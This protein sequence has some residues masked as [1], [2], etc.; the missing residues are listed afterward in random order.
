MHGPNIDAWVNAQETALEAKTTRAANP[1]VET[2]EVLWNEFETV[3]KAAWKDTTRTQSAYE[4]LMK[5]EMKNGDIDTYIATFERLTDAA[6][7]EANAKGT[8]A[9]FKVGLQDHI[10]RCILFH[11]TWPTD[12]DGWKEA[13]RKETEH[14]R[15]IQNAGLAPRNQNN[16]QQPSRNNQQYQSTNTPHN[17]PCNDGIV[18]MDVNAT[19]TTRIPAPP[20]KKLTDEER[21]KLLAE[22]WCFRCRQQGHMAKFCPTR[23]TQGNATPHPSTVTRTTDTTPA[24]SE[25]D[26]S[27]KPP[28][29]KAQ[30]IVAIEK[31]M[32]K[33]EQGAYLDERDM[34]EEDF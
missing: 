27:P 3:F 14:F 32:T 7:W 20:L 30:Q 19:S 9:R 34:G 4:Q 21:K 13:A 23:D 18:P 16:P 6:E 15:E 22:G 8:I 28:L 12:M 31:S 24:K 17:A 2:D 33:E 5:L 25:P 1:I 10:H 11:E 29:S 26:K